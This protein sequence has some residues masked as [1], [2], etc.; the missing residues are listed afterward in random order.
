M[1]C[2]RDWTIFFVHSLEF[3]VQSFLK[4]H[5]SLAGHKKSRDWTKT[6][7][8]SLRW[9]NFFCQPY[10]K[11]TKQLVGHE[12]DQNY[13]AVPFISSHQ[14]LAFSLENK[15]DWAK[16]NLILYPFLGNLITRSAIMSILS[17]E[18][19]SRLLTGITLTRLY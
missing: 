4:I 2:L 18:N 7:A 17:N 9:V 10:E 12:T 8:R 15:V 3:F 19:I 5:H 1:S 13:M 16:I 14:K 11:L 6:I